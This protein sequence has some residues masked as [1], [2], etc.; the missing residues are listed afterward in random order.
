MQRPHW[1][2]E[3]FEMLLELYR[4]KTSRLY[5]ALDKCS[6]SYVALKQYRKAALSPLNRR[7][8]ERE[9]GIHVRQHHPNI[10]MLHAAFED[11]NSYYLVQELAGGGAAG[12]GGG[13][14]L[15]EALKRQPGFKYSEQAASQLVAQMLQALVY[16][17]EQGIIHRDIKPENILLAADGAV[18]L[19]DF[20][21]AID[22]RQE[23]PVTRVGT[24][25]YMG[26]EVL[27][28]PD[29][30]QPEENKDK[31][32][33]AYN[34]QVDTWAVGILAAELI[35]GSPPFMAQSRST[36]Y[37]MIMYRQPP[38]PGWLSPA[39]K[40]FIA[41]ALEKNPADRAT[42]S[43]L[44]QHDW[45][46]VSSQMQL[47]AE[48]RA[49]TAVGPCEQL[50]AASAADEAN[51]VVQQQFE[52]QP[53]QLG[54]QQ[55]AYPP[56]Q[57]HLVTVA[58]ADTAGVAK[59]H[60]IQA[61]VPTKP[62]LE[63]ATPPACADADAAECQKPDNTPAGTNRLVRQVSQYG[64]P[65]HC[66]FY[67]HDRH[68]RSSF[69]NNNWDDF[70][71]TISQST[72]SFSEGQWTNELMALRSP[73][74]ADV[75]HPSTC[76]TN[77][78]LQDVPS[79]SGIL[80]EPG[81]AEGATDTAQSKQ[82]WLLS[83][84]P[85]N[86]FDRIK[87][88]S[89][90]ADLA[91][92][93]INA[94]ERDKGA[95]AHQHFLLELQA[96]PDAKPA[97]AKQQFQVMDSSALEELIAPSL[98]PTDTLRSLGLTVPHALGMAHAGSSH[99]LTGRAMEEVSLSGT[100]DDFIATALSSTQVSFT[101]K[102]SASVP[103]SLSVWAGASARPPSYASSPTPD[104]K[105]ALSGP[106]SP[107][108]A[109]ATLHPVEG[110]H[111]NNSSSHNTQP[112]AA[113]RKFGTGRSSPGAR[114]SRGPGTS[115]RR[116]LWADAE[117]EVENCI[118]A[119]A[120][121][122]PLDTSAGVASVAAANVGSHGSAVAVHSPTTASA[123]SAQQQ[124]RHCYTPLAGVLDEQMPTNAAAEHGSAQ[125]GHQ[126]S[127]ASLSRGE[128]GFRGLARAASRSF[129]NLLQLSG[130]SGGA[131]NDSL[132]VGVR[133]GLVKSFTLGSSNCSVL[134]SV[135]PG[136]VSRPTREPTNSRPASAG[137]SAPALGRHA[138]GS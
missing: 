81:R 84:G 132:N 15:F 128:G 54:G 115:S 32:S 130:S 121:P 36:T 42:A 137:S 73:A 135:Q 109:G 31:V 117:F 49:S 44:L 48:Q 77:S 116:V 100:Y 51:P 107:T 5:K 55:A 28:C 119:P 68:R 19:G 22:S 87:R 58:S 74:Q 30:R 133:S 37:Q 7:Q 56:A 61:P 10:I 21:L 25:D 123:L 92:T 27:V 127:S 62:A 41:V 46:V 39:A 1:C 13:G 125:N 50:P 18:K 14:D 64:H 82:A 106:G 6:G 43:E 89:S 57:P 29:K 60:T 120:A 33:L 78:P 85:R 35:T 11:D 3:Q 24:L 45:L 113:C 70:I 16:L 63:A 80:Q 75:L 122:Q 2:I 108:A 102:H 79:T 53:P 8:V 66:Q 104:Y 103:A 91:Q 72:H 40:A 9:M 65:L 138:A 98:T 97:V 134:H 110:L 59:V 94:G 129:T 93:F 47:L 88:S 69:D 90:R 12:D 112:D 67:P 99:A 124:Q 4:G 118:L 136:A 96:L 23:R 83:S 38:L 86:L 17:H 95:G 20:G 71:E 114:S 126:T 105:A 52:Q 34:T 131:A 101:L 26:P 111:S 76:S